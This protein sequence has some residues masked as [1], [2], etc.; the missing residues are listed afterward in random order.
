MADKHEGGRANAAR[1]GLYIRIAQFV[2]LR[3]DNYWPFLTCMF[4]HGGWAHI[5]GSNH[6]SDRW[7]LGRHRRRAGRLPEEL[8]VAGLVP[9]P[10]V[11]MGVGQL[12]WLFFIL[13]ALQP[14]LQ[15]K[16]PQARASACWPCSSGEEDARHPARAPARDD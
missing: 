5:I 15:Q 2:G 3:F 9:Q 11:G 4:L 6:R 1:E 10:E 12:V 16:L 8:A 14:A 7:G 13:S